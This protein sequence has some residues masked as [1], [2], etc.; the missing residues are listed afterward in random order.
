[1]KK[2]PIALDYELWRNAA[3][4]LKSRGFKVETQESIG[5]LPFV[6]VGR[7]DFG[8]TVFILDAKGKG[9]VFLPEKEFSAI[10]VMPHITISKTKVS[11]DQ[12]KTVDGIVQVV[13]GMIQ[14]Y[15]EDNNKRFEDFVRKAISEGETRRD[16]V[17]QAK[18]GIGGLLTF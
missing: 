6:L 12:L 9:E 13:V 3:S 14:S 5:W 10:G 7:K 8:R 4:V 2:N 18:L 15:I 17:S 16:A 11:P 1:M